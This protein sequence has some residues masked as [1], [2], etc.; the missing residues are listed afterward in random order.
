MWGRHGG[1][2]LL[3]RVADRLRDNGRATDQA[4]SLG[5]DEFAIVQTGPHAARHAA[6]LADRLIRTL[7]APY[8]VEGHRV[9]IGIALGADAAV[10]PDQMFREADNTLYRAKS[11]GRG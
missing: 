10:R 6:D 3:Q 5:G 7:G 1:D 2:S 4:A 11:Q 8:L 9:S